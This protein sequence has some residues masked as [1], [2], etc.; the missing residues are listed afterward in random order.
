EHPLA[1][2]AVPDENNGNV[3]GAEH[4][5]CQG[6]AG[7]DGDDAA[8][9]AVAEEASGAEMLTAAA[10]A[11]D[12]GTLT[13]DLGDQAFHVI[14]AGKEMTVVPM[15]AEDEVA[16]AQPPGDRDARPFLADAGM[17]GAE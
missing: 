16:V 7:A 6:E 14:R 10:A 3:A 8:L 2:G 11:A 9:D 13:H 17:H 15:I 4:A 1:Q 5:L 12:A